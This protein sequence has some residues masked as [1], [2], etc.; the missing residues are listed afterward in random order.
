MQAPQAANSF[1][2]NRIIF[3]PVVVLALFGLMLAGVWCIS[4]WSL[5]WPRCAMRSITG[6]PC[7]ACGCTRSLIAWTELDLT[8][9]FL[10][11]PLFFLLSVVSLIS[12]TWNWLRRRHRTGNAAHAI[13]SAPLP[14]LPW[15]TWRLAGV[16]LVLNWLYLC[17][18]LP[19]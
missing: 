7:P 18:W 5:P 8:A 4:H 3:N 1:P 15:L 10:F 16:L 14:W 19:K 2:R 17:W 13:L 11:N 9:A 6:L 12:C